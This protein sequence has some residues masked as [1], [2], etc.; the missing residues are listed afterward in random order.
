MIFTIHTFTLNPAVDYALDIDEIKFG[1]T[2]RSS[3]ETFR[4]GGK[5]INVSIL[6]NNLGK[7][8]TCLGILGGFTGDFIKKELREN[9]QHII[10]DFVESE[11]P[12]RIN[13]KLKLNEETEINSSGMQ[14][15]H[16][17]IEKLLEK[18]DSISEKD[19]V[20]FSGSF[21]K[22]SPENLL[23][24]FC[25][26]FREKNINFA[27]DT[28]SSSTIDVLKYHPFL[29]KPNLAELSSLV[30]KELNSEIEIKAEARKLVE[31]GAQNVIVSLGQR[32]SI[33]VSSELCLKSIPPTGMLVDSVG[34]GDSL[35]AGFVFGLEEGLNVKE[36]FKFASACGTASAYSSHLA[37]S[38]EIERIHNLTT[39]IDLESD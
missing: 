22:N 35:V 25:K 30:G 10:C 5:G 23:E 17:E 6:L 16:K 8:S 34:A 32:G 21:P 12:T 20:V 1:E 39:I 31:L 37:T 27:I 11:N 14:M 29:I 24:I 33:L 15:S 28:T 19:F 3:K 13:V 36:C 9:Y 7:T 2:N 18:I 38:E 26:R 4:V